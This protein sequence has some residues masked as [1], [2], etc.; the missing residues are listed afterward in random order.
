MIEMKSPFQTLSVRL[1]CL[2]TGL[3]LMIMATLSAT[4]AAAQQTYGLRAGDSLRVEVLED[5]SLNRSVLIAPDGRISFPQAGTMSVAGSTVDAVQGELVSRLTPSFAAPPTV[6]VSLEKL[7]ER[8]VRP[9]VQAPPAVP[10]AAP[11]ISVYIVGEANKLGKIDVAPGT[12]ILQMFAVMG[13][14]TKF[15]ATKRVQLRR[16][17]AG[18]TEQVYTLNY[19]QIQ[20]GLIDVGQ[21]ILMDGDVIV[22]PQ[23]R[24]FE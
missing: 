15:A 22:I 10:V 24:L 16:T 20:K 5:P 12:T 4:P 19:P 21:S 3:C 17:E 8:V 18:G 2:F 13:G 6:F 1:S 9:I 14:F 23:R 7:A 11:I